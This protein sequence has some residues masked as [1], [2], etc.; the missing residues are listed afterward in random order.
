MCRKESI[1]WYW[2]RSRFSEDLQSPTCS[3]SPGKLWNPQ[4]GV[5]SLCLLPAGT[6][7][8]VPASTSSLCHPL[9][10]IPVGELFL[11]VCILFTVVLGREWECPWHRAWSLCWHRGL[12]ERPAESW[13]SCRVEYSE[14]PSPYLACSYFYRCLRCFF[15]FQILHGSSVI[16]L[17]GKWIPIWSN[18]WFEGDL[19]GALGAKALLL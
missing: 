14:C 9:I 15:P 18:M 19:H 5:T 8:A 1:C 12:P 10:S 13:V 4:S 6:G 3:T 16:L 11:E 17:A 7:S 2:M